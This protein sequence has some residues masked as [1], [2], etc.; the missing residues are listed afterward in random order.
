MGG[1]TGYTSGVVLEIKIVLVSIKEHMTL[2]PIS[3]N[4]HD[5]VGYLVGMP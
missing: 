2:E 3:N 1:V 4:R 5:I